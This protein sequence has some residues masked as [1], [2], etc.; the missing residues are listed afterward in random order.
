MKAKTIGEKKAGFAFSRKLSY[1]YQQ[2]EFSCWPTTRQKN[3]CKI[4]ATLVAGVGCRLFSLTLPLFFLLL[5]KIGA[6][7]RLPYRPGDL[8]AGT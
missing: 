6:N 3:K 7:C 4:N 8:Q 1:K 2:A 5:T